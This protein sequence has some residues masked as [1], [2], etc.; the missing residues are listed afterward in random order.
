M[1]NAHKADKTSSGKIIE[2]K[3]MEIENWEMDFD[4][5]NEKRLKSTEKLLFHIYPAI[6]TQKMS[7]KQRA[8]AFFYIC[9][10]VQVAL[11]LMLAKRYKVYSVSA[12]L[13]CLLTHYVT[14]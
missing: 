10:L 11:Q 3:Q 2:K 12:N 14:K 7:L 4:F 5:E 1:Y 6:A 13:L 9:F 8:E